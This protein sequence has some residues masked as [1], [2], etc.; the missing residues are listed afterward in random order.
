MNILCFT[1]LR[2][3]NSRG[4]VHLLYIEISRCW[5]SRWAL[6]LTIIKIQYRCS[7]V[8]IMIYIRGSRWQRYIRPGI[9]MCPARRNEEWRRRKP[10]EKISSLSPWESSNKFRRGLFSYRYSKT[11]RSDHIASTPPGSSYQPLPQILSP[12]STAL[13]TAHHVPPSTS[14]SR[15]PLGLYLLLFRLV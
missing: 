1:V 3:L 14:L 4:C 11:Y 5:Y 9:V 15:N 8:R 13:P 12:L 2:T 6:A 7:A 10:S